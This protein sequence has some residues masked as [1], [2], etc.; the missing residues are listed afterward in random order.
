MRHYDVKILTNVDPFVC[1]LLE[2]VLQSNLYQGL[3]GV[4]FDERSG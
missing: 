4:H 1:L 2:T 3:A